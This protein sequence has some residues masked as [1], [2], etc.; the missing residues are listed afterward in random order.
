MHMSPLVCIC[1]PSCA[2][3]KKYIDDTDYTIQTLRSLHSNAVFYS[4]I[5]ICVREFT[6]G[7]R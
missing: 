7:A 5:A 6:T 1:V 3:W 4:K 2:L